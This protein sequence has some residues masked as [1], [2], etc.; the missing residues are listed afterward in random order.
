[1]AIKGKV[2]GSVQ[3]LKKAIKNSGGGVEFLLRVGAD[4]E[5]EVRFL[6]EPDQWFTYDEHYHP[7]YKFFPCDTEQCLGCAEGL[8]TQRRTAMIVLDVENDQVRVFAAPYTVVEKLLKRYDRYHTMLDRN[9]IVMRSGSTQSDTTYDVESGPAMKM[10]TAKYMKDLPSIEDVLTA[11][12]PS[13]DDDDDDDDFLPP[14]KKSKKA[15]GKKGKAK[16]TRFDDDDDDDLP[17]IPRQRRAVKKPSATPR[18]TDA[19]KALKRKLSR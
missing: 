2:A 18:N 6:T 8:S 12:I 3:A 9:Y 10:K 1:M 14:R 13:P 19:V 11:Q 4:E 15:A 7:D 17:S 5:V 16:S